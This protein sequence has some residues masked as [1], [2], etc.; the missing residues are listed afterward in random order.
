MRPWRPA[1]ESV[2]RNIRA[3][4]GI[5]HFPRGIMLVSTGKRLRAVTEEAYELAKR[6]KGVVG[7]GVYAAKKIG[8]NYYFSIEG[9]QIFGDHIE[10]RVVEV[11][12]EE[13]EQWMKGAPIKREGAEPRSII[14]VRLGRVY[15]GSGK[16]SRDGKIYPL[17]PKERQINA[18]LGRFINT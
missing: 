7:L 5:N 15:L 8:E 4:Y 13:A 16:V 12:W 11:T 18:P 14:V 10:N 9:S 2:V 6:L 1:D 3:Y 17:I